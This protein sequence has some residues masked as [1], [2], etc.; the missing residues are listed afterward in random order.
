MHPDIDG[1]I[2]AALG[3]EVRAVLAGL[4]EVRRYDTP[5]SPRWI[6]RA[7][8]HRFLVVQTGIGPERVRI[9][10]AGMEVASAGACW[11]LSTGCAGALVPDL[12]PG[13]VVVA[14]RIIDDHGA[15]VGRP[16]DAEAL[17]LRGW[18]QTRGIV[19]RVGSF[20]SVGRPLLTALDKRRA[21]ERLGAIAVEMEGAALAA[22]AAARGIRLVAVLVILDAVD[23]AVPD[24]GTPGD[25]RGLAGALARH[26]AAF[27]RAARLWPAKRTAQTALER[28]FREFVAGDALGALEG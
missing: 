23:V 18:A 1:I 17:A 25:L 9:A 26:P 28:V 4:A 2:A 22:A 27:A 14:S 12:A 8:R 20:V 10:L 21:H 13:A 3:W 24:L 6:G 11:L 15:L 5:G 16:L 19:V 7:G